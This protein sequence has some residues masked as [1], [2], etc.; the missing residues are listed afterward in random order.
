MGAGMGFLGGM[1]VGEMMS[2]ASHHSREAYSCDSGGFS[3]GDSGGYGGEI[4]LLLTDAHP[5]TL[6]ALLPHVRA[7]C[8]VQSSRSDT[9]GVMACHYEKS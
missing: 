2:S 8:V 5:C 9:V 3:G 7:S 6:D 1:M 4:L